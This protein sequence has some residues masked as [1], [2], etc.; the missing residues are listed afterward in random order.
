MLDFIRGGHQI[1]LTVAID[2]TASNGD[3][4][5]STSLHFNSPT[6][7]N[8]YQNAITSIGSILD[9]YDSDHLYP[10]FGY[11]AKLPPDWQVSH[12]FPLN[13]NYQDPHVFGVNGILG[14]YNNALQQVV[15]HGPTNMAPVIRQAA[16]GARSNGETSYH[17][18]L[19]ITDGV[20]S[21][22]DAT[23]GNYFFVKKYSFFFR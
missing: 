10:C 21:D 23:I 16:M 15:L 3:P 13:F 20:I 2:F 4:R 17:I 19:I 5:N 7:P 18:L 8:Q 1:N 22:L 14:A 9:Y 11:G 12:M 6:Q